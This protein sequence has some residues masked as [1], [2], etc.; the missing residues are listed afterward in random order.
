M[1]QEEQDRMLRNYQE[2]LSQL[3]SAYITE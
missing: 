1:T 3:D 2:Q